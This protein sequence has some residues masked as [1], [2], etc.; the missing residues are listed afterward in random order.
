MGPNPGNR[1]ACRPVPGAGHQEIDT[2]TRLDDPDR[3]TNFKKSHRPGNPHKDNQME[4][5]PQMPDLPSSPLDGR[6]GQGSSSQSKGLFATEA[7]PSSEGTPT[8]S[9]G[10]EP[11][12]W[13]HSGQSPNNLNDREFSET[14]DY[15]AS[16]R[17]LIPLPIVPVG[18]NL[19]DAI[20]ISDHLA[21]Y[22]A[23]QSE[24]V[25]TS[26][27][28]AV[29]DQTNFTRH[30]R[31]IEQIPSPHAIFARRSQESHHET[32]SDS[33]VQGRWFQDPSLKVH[34]WVSTREITSEHFHNNRAQRP[35]VNL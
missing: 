30:L 11:V 9:F 35:I 33:S 18:M 24:Q 32:S 3:S 4:L 15:A 28:S 6:N 34:P 8:D 5:S 20:P 21:E 13:E 19:P 10:F 16:L 12:T 22:M 7:D 29:F 23:F 14:T 2:K 17:G 31:R 25:L 27:P 1:A 26:K